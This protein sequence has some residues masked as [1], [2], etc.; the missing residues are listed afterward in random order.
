MKVSKPDITL[1]PTEVAD[2]EKLFQFQLDKK[3]ENIVQF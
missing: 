3:I 2:L 1:R